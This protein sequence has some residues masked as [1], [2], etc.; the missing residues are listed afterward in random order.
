MRNTHRDGIEK[1]RKNPI[2]S[3]PVVLRSSD[4]SLAV[5]EGHG[6]TIR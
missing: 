1:S 5:L 2:N 6:Y 3:D 4:T